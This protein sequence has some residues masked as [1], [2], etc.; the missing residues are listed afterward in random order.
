MK[1]KIL[2]TAHYILEAERDEFWDKKTGRLLPE[3]DECLHKDF[4]EEIEFSSELVADQY[5]IEHQIIDYPGYNFLTCP[6][7]ERVL[8][9][10]SKPNPIQELD[11]CVVVGGVEVSSGFHYMSRHAGLNS[12]F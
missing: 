1:R 2:I 7:C 5:Y 11:K 12:V 10:P 4:P 3:I 9:N 6:F 8:T